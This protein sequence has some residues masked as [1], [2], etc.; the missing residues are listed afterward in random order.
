MDLDAGIWIVHRSRYD[1]EHRR[2]GGTDDKNLSVKRALDAVFHDVVKT[3]IA[4]R[5]GFGS[6]I[7]HDMAVFFIEGYPNGFSK[8]HSGIGLY[9]LNNV[10]WRRTYFTQ[11]LFTKYGE[12]RNQ[13]PV[14]I[15]YGH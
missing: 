8:I 3:V 1:V 6:E 14:F 2:N 11:C 12:R 15:R 5:R 9:V 7:R 4:E 10:P 13:L